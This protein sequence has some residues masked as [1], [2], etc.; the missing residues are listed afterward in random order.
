M[1]ALPSKTGS[2]SVT[3]AALLAAL[4]ATLMTGTILPAQAQGYRPGYPVAIE[5]EDDAI[6]PPRAV[7]FRLGRAGFTGMTHPRFD[8]ETYRVEADSPWGNRVQ[9]VVDART[10]RILDRERL[11]APLIPPGTVPG[12]RRPGYGW[13]EADSRPPWPRDEAFRDR[14]PRGGD[15]WREEGRYAPVPLPRAEP[16]PSGERPEERRVAARPLPQG[17]PQFEPAAPSARVAP[18]PRAS[19]NAGPNPLGLNPDS[20]AAR[21]GA[22]P[23]RETPP[24]GVKSEAPK[25]EGTRPEAPRRTA[26]RPNPPERIEAPAALVPPLA[27]KP[28]Q[29]AKPVPATKEPAPAKAA[30]AAQA[31]APDA[32]PAEGGWKTPPEGNRPV[33]VIGGITQVPGKDEPAKD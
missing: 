29:S 13:T 4:A 18:A 9:L 21:T 28:T 3:G 15:G 25:T 22:A 19:T 23:R 17:A 6:L 27:P 8:G 11:E 31:K 14:A 7:I 26:A 12:G 16:L 24:E 1:T 10:G 30:E 2:R 33:R 20:T 32:R 5:D